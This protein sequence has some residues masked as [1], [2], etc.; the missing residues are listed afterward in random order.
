M[1]SNQYFLAVQAKI[2]PFHRDF[3]IYIVFWEEIKKIP[4]INAEWITI[5]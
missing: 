3:N 2:V 4:S 1:Q 5:Y